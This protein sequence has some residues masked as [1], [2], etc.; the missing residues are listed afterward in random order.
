[1]HGYYYGPM[2]YGRFPVWQ[3]ILLDIAQ[4]AL[5]ILVFTLVAFAISRLFM[6]SRRHDFMR[7]HG[8]FERTPLEILQRR[9]ALGKITKTQYEEMRRELEGDTKVEQK[10]K[11][12]TTKSEATK[13]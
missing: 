10:Q 13:K 6:G 11:E 9:Y 4:L 1:M 2:M 3:N 8:R 5:G 12:S 7:M